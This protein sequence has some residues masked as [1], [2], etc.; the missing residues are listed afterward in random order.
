MSSY[1]TEPSDVDRHAAPETVQ[2]YII[3]L[4]S[5]LAA[6]RDA[7]AELQAENERLEELKLR[8]T[9]RDKSIAQLEEWLA[10][11]DRCAAELQAKVE[12]V[13]ALATSS[14]TVVHGDTLIVMNKTEFMAA[15]E[16]GDE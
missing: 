5:E 3:D 1:F 11:R 12:R 8:L 15:L 6:E 10:H 7:V 4:E 14:E 16:G 13:I 2:T 9:H